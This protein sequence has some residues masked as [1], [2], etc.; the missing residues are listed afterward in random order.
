MEYVLEF[1]CVAKATQTSLRVNLWS[2]LQDQF[3]EVAGDR[4]H[5]N[6]AIKLKWEFTT[7][8]LA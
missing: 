5:T 8:L 3:P 4:V 1:M 7:N 2:E 6:L